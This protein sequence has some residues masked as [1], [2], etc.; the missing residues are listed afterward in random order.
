MLLHRLLLAVT[1][2]AQAPTSDTPCRAARRAQQQ[3]GHH[4]RALRAYD[5][6]RHFV[7][8]GGTHLDDEWI[9]EVPF[10]VPQPLV[11]GLGCGDGRR[12]RCDVSSPWRCDLRMTRRRGRDPDHANDV[13]RAQPRAPHRAVH[14]G[15]CT[16][17]AATPGSAKRRRRTVSLGS[18]LAVPGLA[19]LECLLVALP[20][21]GALAPLARLNSPMWAAALPGSIVIGTFGPLWHPSFACALVVLA[22][23]TVPL[24]AV[25]AMIGIVRMPRALLVCTATALTLGPVLAS[26]TVR[27]LSLSIVTALGCLTVGVTLTR[28]IPPRW[29]L[30]GVALM[31]IV[32]ALF[33][34]VGIGQAAVA[35]MDTAD[36]LVRGPHFDHATVGWIS[37]DFPDLVLAGV[38]GGFVAGVRVQ[39]R[40]AMTLALLAMGS[41]ML[42]PVVKFMPATVPIALTFGLLSV[43]NR[44]ERLSRPLSARPPAVPM[45]SPSPAPA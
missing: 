26:G 13:M 31:A 42:V 25:I 15:I 36:R 41:E 22:T 37:L 28:L 45:R 18:A 14:D 34:T 23:V 33:L 21:R 24:L 39:R 19:V 11:V 8:L 44:P 2:A 20:R 7:R 3:R 17:R 40:A 16:A 35:S 30:V 10:H 12:V 6:S 1:G 43:W 32:D 29:L 27:Q 38:L 5:G 4:E 9:C